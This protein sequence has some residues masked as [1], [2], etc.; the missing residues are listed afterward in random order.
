MVGLILRGADRSA[1]AVRRRLDAYGTFL[2]V[3]LNSGGN[4]YPHPFDLP[5]LVLEEVNKVGHDI[6]RNDEPLDFLI[7]HACRTWSHRRGD[8]LPHAPPA[9]D[10]KSKSCEK[11][12][13]RQEDP[14]ELA[15]MSFHH[16]RMIQEISLWCLPAVSPARWDGTAQ[17]WISPGRWDVCRGAG[18]H[19]TSPLQAR[20]RALVHVISLRL[21]GCHA[22]TRDLYWRLADWS[23]D[24]AHP[25]YRTPH[26]DE[27]NGD[28]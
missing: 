10:E 11:H 5:P 28:Q 7:L 23:L 27:M 18:C 12:D 1:F 19:R 22:S 16:L 25:P 6:A 21:F 15:P 17:R 24:W 8:R 2:I 20:L 26:E 3:F 13:F 9:N 14:K 4:S